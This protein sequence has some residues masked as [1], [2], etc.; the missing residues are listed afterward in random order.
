[1]RVLQASLSTLLILDSDPDWYHSTVDASPRLIALHLSTSRL[2]AKS[3]GLGVNMI[4]AD[5]T[6]PL[7]TSA[8]AR[9]GPIFLPDAH[10]HY[11]NRT[12][13]WL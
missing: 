5:E 7:Y 4:P 6:N 3:P 1:M 10:H 13:R 9:M 2:L 12:E 11:D 8:S